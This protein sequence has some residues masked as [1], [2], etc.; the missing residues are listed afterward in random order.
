MEHRKLGLITF[1]EICVFYRCRGDSY[2]HCYP[3]HHTAG[4]LF[5]SVSLRCAAVRA[6]IRAVLRVTSWS[7]SFQIHWRDVPS[8][9]LGRTGT[10]W[11]CGTTEVYVCFNSPEQIHS[12]GSVYKKTDKT[13]NHINNA[14]K[15]CEASEVWGSFSLSRWVDRPE[16]TWNQVPGWKL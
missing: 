4:L 16:G 1:Q 9:S 14:L 5:E 8:S 12:Q 2:G 7:L 6:V 10:R 13:Y 3:C 15:V 11:F